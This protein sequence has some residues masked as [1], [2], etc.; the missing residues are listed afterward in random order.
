MIVVKYCDFWVLV[1]MVR[2]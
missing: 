1:P 2:F